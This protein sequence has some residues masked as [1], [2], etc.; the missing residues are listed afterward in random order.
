MSPFTTQNIIFFRI[1]QCGIKRLISMKSSQFI[2][3]ESKIASDAFCV[4]KVLIVLIMVF[5]VTQFFIN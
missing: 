3:I 1:G 4:Y 2:Q 5:L